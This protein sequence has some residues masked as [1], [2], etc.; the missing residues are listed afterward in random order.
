MC[1]I[2]Q[3]GW[4]ITRGTQ[5]ERMVLHLESY[6]YNKLHPSPKLTASLRLLIE[7]LSLFVLDPCLTFLSSA[8]I[9]STP[10][11]VY[12]LVH[13]DHRAIM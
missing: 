3:N 12:S 7:S 9:P 11:Q 4:R 2:H 10:N 13:V 6:C 5:P 8:C 1:I